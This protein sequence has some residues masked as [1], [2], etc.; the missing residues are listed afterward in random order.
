MKT[1]RKQ[2]WDWITLLASCWGLDQSPKLPCTRFEVMDGKDA[3]KKAPAAKGAE[4]R[5][6]SCK[7]REVCR[8]TD[9]RGLR[10][11]SSTMSC[12][13]STC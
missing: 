5:S 13:P 3:R 7:A 2:G 4:E 12:K 1:S 8:C 9:V 6:L 11:L 10:K